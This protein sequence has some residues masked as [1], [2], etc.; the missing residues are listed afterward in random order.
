M[1]NHNKF[2]LNKNYIK[3]AFLVLFCFFSAYFI[4]T[5][6]IPVGKGC[7]AIALAMGGWHLLKIIKETQDNSIENLLDQNTKRLKILA[8]NAQDIIY[9]YRMA[10]QKKFDYVSPASTTILGYTPD[11]HCQDPELWSKILYEEDRFIFQEMQ[12][13]SPEL[14]KGPLVLRWRAKSGMIVWTEQRNSLVYDSKNN[15]IAI[16]GI[17]RDIT[18]QKLAEKE[19]K[20]QAIQQAVVADLGQDALKGADLLTLMDDSV[21]MIAQTMEMDYCYIMEYLPEKKILLLRSYY[22]W[23]VPSGSESIPSDGSFQGSYAMES[24][25]SVVVEDFT[26]ERRFG[27]F[28]QLLEFGIMSGMSVLIPGDIH[29]LGV[30]SVNSSQTHSFNKNDMN[31]LLAIANMLSAAIHRKNAEKE[32]EKLTK[33]LGDALEEKKNIQEQIIQKE[34]LHALGQMASGIVHDFNNALSPIIGLTELLLQSESNLQDTAKVAHYLEWIKTSAQDGVHIVKTLKNFYRARQEGEAFYLVNVN[35]AILQTMKLTEAK[36]K[37]IPESNNIK[38]EI[39]EDMHE[40]PLIYGNEAELREA[41]TNLLCNA[42]DALPKGGCIIFHTHAEET[43]IA[44]E[45]RDN[46]IGMSEEVRKKCLEPFFTT[47]GANGTGLGLSMVYGV[48]QR[49]EGNI[50]IISEEGK[51]TTFLITLP[52]Q[53]QYKTIQKE[54]DSIDEALE[55]KLNILVV[56]DKEQVLI[57][58][59]EYLAYDGHRVTTANCGSKGLSLFLANDFD[60]VITDLAM[61]DM[62]GDEMSYKIKKLSPDTPIILITGFDKEFDKAMNKGDEEKQMSIDMLVQK[63]VNLKTLRNAMR[64][65]MKKKGQSPL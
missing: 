18:T 61:P 21:M 5:G 51:G 53:I 24:G 34:R 58:M 8:E 38:I 4:V 25:I 28:P 15:L 65:V 63:P 60:L 19:I 23:T 13:Q 35:D 3:I 17:I 10:P 11:E 48:V 32:M 50:D 54:D 52:I 43:K 55:Q 26:K 14:L 33:S 31:F 29:P 56:D 41:F 6:N 16:E 47:K 59:E 62:N 36:W 49:H 45:I 2:L 7:N 42:V 44:V 64:E 20:N 46:G 9:R 12:T 27:I 37:T 40:I 22:G 57:T 30:L 1:K 39:K